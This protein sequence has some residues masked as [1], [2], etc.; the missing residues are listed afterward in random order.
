V[1]HAQLEFVVTAGDTARSLGSGDVEVLGTPALLA[2]CEAAT[3]LAAAPVLPEGR[4]SVGTR[5]ELDHRVPTPVGG[6][7]IV[8]AELVHRD[9]R[10]L[11]FVVAAVDGSGTVVGAGEVTRVVVDR[12]RFAAG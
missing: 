9:G 7:V 1:T 5:V 10:V 11:R 3:C 6:R 2:W 4:T 12:A 8:S